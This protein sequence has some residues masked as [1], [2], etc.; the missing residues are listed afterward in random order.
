MR[1]DAPAPEPDASIAADRRGVSTALGYTLTLSITA[2][3]IAGLLTAGGTL[4]ENQQRAVVTD[5]LTVTGQQLAAG[6]ED[7]DRLAGTMRNGTVRLS[8][9]LPSDV[10]AGGGYSI[11][12]VNRP[13]P[14]DQPALATIVVTAENVDVSRNVSFRTEHRVANRTVPGGPV[15]V[16]YHDTDGDEDRELVVGGKREIEGPRTPEAVVYVDADTGNLSTVHPDG[17]ITDYGVEA[18]AIGPKQVDF[19]DDGVEEVPYV[20]AS[21]ELKLVDSNGQVQTLTGGDAAYSPQQ[22]SYGTVVGVGEWRGETSVFYM[23]RSDTGGNDEATI[24]R[25]SPGSGPEKVTVGGSGVEANAIAGVGDINDDGDADLV[26]VGT[27][28][29]IRYIDDNT[30]VDTG[31]NVGTAV[32]IGVG[33]PRQFAN[34]EP[35]RVPFVGGSDNVK[36]LRH[37]DGSSTVTALTGGAAPT[38]VAAIDFVGDD[39]LE[40]VYVDG[41][42]GTLRYVTLS[43]A[44]GTIYGPDGN[45]IEV[46]EEDGV[47]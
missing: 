41:S 28:Q 30:T 5:E 13:T 29:R 40:V 1:E 33:A 46:T 16:S 7:A 10:G 45:P 35:D 9:W 6:F 8:V 42:D 15:T 24:Y 14:D 37:T 12:V 26:Y 32:G 11:R 20:T 34:G 17:E 25:V 27:S 21:N 38:F 19:D 23:N 18:N 36:L 22:N 4:V 31:T 3:L 39:R 44:T 47:A 43:G 2:V